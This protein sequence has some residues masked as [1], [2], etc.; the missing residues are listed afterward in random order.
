MP[1]NTDPPDSAPPLPAAA[2]LDRPLAIVLIG[3]FILFVIA[4]FVQERYWV[5]QQRTLAQL[6]ILN[7]RV[8]AAQATEDELVSRVGEYLT[9]QGRIVDA[10]E[11]QL[12]EQS[13]REELDTA[14]KLLDD[15]SVHEESLKLHLM[16]R[17]PR[18]DVQRAFSS[19]LTLLDA[20]ADDVDELR[21]PGADSSDDQDEVIDRCRE[22]IEDVENALAGLSQALVGYIDRLPAQPDRSA[23]R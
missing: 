14:D 22:D 13:L 16:T 12:D 9:A 18:E 7:A 23:S 20:L 4:W 2:L 8:A 17:F 11:D 19:M 3:G 5:L 10:F 15:W 6:A 21:D 1:A